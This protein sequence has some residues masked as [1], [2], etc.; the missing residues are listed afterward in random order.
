MKTYYKRDE[1]NRLATEKAIEVLNENKE[2]VLTN[3]SYSGYGDIHE[4]LIGLQD[5][6]K[7]GSYIFIGFMIGSEYNEKNLVIVRY[8]NGESKMIE[9]ILKLY[10]TGR[11]KTIYLTNEADYKKYVERRRNYYDSLDKRKAKHY[12][13][14]QDNKIAEKLLQRIKNVTGKKI[15]KQSLQIEAYKNR[16]EIFYYYRNV[17]KS[18]TIYK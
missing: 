14:D 18:Y 10:E 4:T 11:N 6:R 13:L 7:Y 5:T 15:K 16:Y 8:E 12:S 9:N 2:Y 3:S 1:I 17:K